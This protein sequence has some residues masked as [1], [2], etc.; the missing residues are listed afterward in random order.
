MRIVWFCFF[1]QKTAYEMRMSDWSSDVC[2]SDLY[3]FLGMVREAPEL[4]AAEIDAVRATSDRPFGVN[5]IP[6]ATDPDLL[7]AE[8]AVCF[9]RSDERSGGKEC[10]S[11]FRSR[12][13]PY[14]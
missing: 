12:W 9:D 13:L 3:G 8:L 6:A 14:T 2:S 11:P 5:L 10:V 4:I 7:A 1:K